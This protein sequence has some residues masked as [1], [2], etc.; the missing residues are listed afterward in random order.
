M[1]KD[2]TVPGKVGAACRGKVVG[3]SIV[4]GRVIVVRESYSLPVEPPLFE[5][6]TENNEATRDVSV[7]GL[8]WRTGL[9]EW[10]RLL[11]AAAMYMVDPR[12]EKEVFKD[13]EELVGGEMAERIASLVWRI[14][15][16]EGYTLD[17]CS[18]N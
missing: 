6:L 12:P 3:V 15:F 10:E 9:E 14:A 18:K 8:R 5:P 2:N 1:A 7:D 17:E 11:L 16:G 4:P 13:M